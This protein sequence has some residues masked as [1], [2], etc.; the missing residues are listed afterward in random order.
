MLNY[1]HTSKFSAELKP[2]LVVPTSLVIGMN[3]HCNFD[4]FFKK[5]HR[6]IYGKQKTVSV[7]ILIIICT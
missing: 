2:K 6:K 4:I 3:F 5:K 7:S 1:T